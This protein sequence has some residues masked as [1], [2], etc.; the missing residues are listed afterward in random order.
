MRHTH[1]QR[2]RGTDTGR[3]RSRLYGGS[4]TWDLIL[5]LQD[6]AGVEGGVKPLSHLGC[7]KPSHPAE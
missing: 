7:P 4:L 6:Q 2:E 3:G 5:G 1:T